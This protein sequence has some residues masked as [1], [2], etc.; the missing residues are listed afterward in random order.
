MGVGPGDFRPTVLVVTHN[1]P[2]DPEDQAGQF[3]QTLISPIA[4]RY[5]FVVIAPHHA[6]LPLSETLGPVEVV[7]F[8]YASDGDETLAYAGDMHEQVLK[9]WRKRLLFLAFLRRMR[10]AVA[11]AIDLESPVAMHIHWWIPGALAAAG[12]AARRKVPYLLTTHGS[13]VTLIAKFGWLRPVAGPLFRRA[14]ARTAVSTYLQNVMADLFG[15]DSVLL[16]M[17]YDDSKFTPQE[18]MDRTPPIVTCIGRMIERKGQNYLLLAGRLLLD[19]GIDCCIQLVGDGPLKARLSALAT[20]QGIADRVIFTGNV[21]HDAIPALIYGS[22]LVVLPS[23]ADWKGEVEGLGMVLAEASACGRPVIGTRLGGP[24]DAVYDGRTG[25]LVPPAD[26]AALADAIAAILSDRE[27]MRSFGQAGVN[28]ARAHFSPASQA[29]KLA[30]LIEE[31]RR[32]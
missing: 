13:D 31:I 11:R 19:R 28:F 26:P 32:R 23:V 1:Y 24:I 10:Q 5:R 7:R 22:A 29:G 6:G 25:L 3:I 2:R 15:V 27:K 8:R 17:P 20:E 18:P 14:A 16:P 4:D 12:L 21:P 30:D 9:S